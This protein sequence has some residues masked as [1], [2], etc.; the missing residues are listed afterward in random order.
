[1]FSAKIKKTLVEKLP[2]L[3]IVIPVLATVKGILLF[4]NSIV[5]LNVKTTL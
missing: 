5:V 4:L 2:G 1:M 3:L